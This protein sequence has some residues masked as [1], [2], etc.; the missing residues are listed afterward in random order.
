[1]SNFLFSQST[2]DLWMSAFPLRVIRYSVAFLLHLKP[3]I[4]FRGHFKSVLRFS[5]IVR[6]MTPS[7]PRHCLVTRARTYREFGQSPCL[8]HLMQPLIQG[9]SR[10]QIEGPTRLLE[11]SAV[12]QRELFRD[13]A[14]V[15]WLLKLYL[16]SLLYAGVGDGAQKLGAVSYNMIISLLH[17]TPSS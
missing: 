4:L 15:F 8:S 16:E 11:S 1:M 9:W 7:L 12:R 6:I 3:E 13:S 5:V 14:R 10:S 17:D 2:E